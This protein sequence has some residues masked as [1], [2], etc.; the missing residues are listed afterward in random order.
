MSFLQTSGRET[1]IRKR[2]EERK[3][4]GNVSEDDVGRERRFRRK[5]REQKLRAE[6]LGKQR[7][8]KEYA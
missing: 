7:Q 3:T 1:V 5:R 2:V 4:I 8:G 6:N